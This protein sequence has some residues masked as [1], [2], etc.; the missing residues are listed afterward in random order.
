MWWLRCLLLLFSILLC[1]RCPSV[2]SIWTPPDAVEL[3]AKLPHKPTPIHLDGLQLCQANCQSSDRLI[4]STRPTDTHPY[5][6]A[7]AK[8]PTKHQQFC[9]MGCELFFSETPNNVTCK[10]NCDWYYRFQATEGYSNLAV[11]AKLECRDGCDI[12]YLVCQA[13]YFCKGGSMLPCPIGTYREP[14]TKAPY[15]AS[16]LKPN[17]NWTSVTEAIK[18]SKLNGTTNQCI[19]CPTG[20]YRGLIQ[21]KSTSDCSLCPVGKYSDKLGATYITQ[22]VRCPAGTFGEYEGVSRCT[23]IAPKS[24]D[25]LVQIKYVGTF[26]YYL[27]TRFSIKINATN[28][29]GVPYKHPT[30]FIDPHTGL[31][32]SAADPKN[33]YGVDY[34]RESIPYIGRW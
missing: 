28:A 32:E 7:I 2:G 22:C 18:Y 34:Y 25:Y 17:Y 19:G 14:V 9:K 11:E 15:N 29:A 16:T 23:Y 21:G 3:D 26:H 20:K 24:S 30:P 4:N 33:P 31:P 10:T 13:G 5:P 12:G 1:T 8:F 6:W 27:Q